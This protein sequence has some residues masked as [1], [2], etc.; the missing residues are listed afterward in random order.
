M[1]KLFKGC[2]WACEG[3]ALKKGGVELEIK[4]RNLSAIT[5]KRI[6]ELAKKQGLSREAYLRD[7]LEKLACI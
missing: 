3:K 7:H 4:V 6:D 2:E 1:V 5:V